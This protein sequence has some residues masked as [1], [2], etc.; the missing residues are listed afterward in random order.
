MSID[1]AGSE[2][3]VNR[4]NEVAARQK[5]TRSRT[6]KVRKHMQT[7]AYK[8]DLAVKLDKLHEEGRTVAYILSSP[9]IRGFEIV[10]Y[11]EE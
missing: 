6:V 5:G 4:S 1:E 7:T 2:P 3:Q 10:S 8:Q 9:D 11:T